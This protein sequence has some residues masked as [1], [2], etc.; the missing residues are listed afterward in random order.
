MDGLRAALAGRFCDR[1]GHMGFLP[2]WLNPFD[3]LIVLALLGGAALGFV[4]GLVRMALSL[5][6]LYVAA[7]VA[8]IG[9][10]FAGRWI[11]YIT[12][13]PKTISQ[14]LG[15]L[16]LLA[17]TAI[18]LNFVLRKTYRDTELPGIRQIDQLGGMIIGFFLATL[19][20]GFCILVIAFILGAPVGEDSVLHMNLVNYFQSSN[21]IPIFYSFLPI[22]LA[23]LKPWMPRGLP[24]ILV[25]RL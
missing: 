1:G 13:L 14:G 23:T 19:W 9:Y 2:G 3:F 15:F 5:L 18:V 4:R 20:I 24:D 16:F 22:A 12:T 25:F 11:R 10:E 21:L 8:T 7:V 6:V 17:L